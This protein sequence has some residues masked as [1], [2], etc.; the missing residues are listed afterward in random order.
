MR[1]LPAVSCVTVAAPTSGVRQAITG[2]PSQPFSSMLSSSVLIPAGTFRQNKV[3][4]GHLASFQVVVCG[5]VL[6]KKIAKQREQVH[7]GTVLCCTFFSL[8]T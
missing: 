1:K 7:D 4:H 2:V 6:I 3:T 8:T 5:K